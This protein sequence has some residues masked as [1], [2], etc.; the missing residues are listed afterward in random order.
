M[1]GWQSAQNWLVHCCL[2]FGLGFLSK[3]FTTA[4]LKASENMSVWI[5]VFIVFRTWL[6]T[7]LNAL[8]KN[9]VATGSVHGLEELHVMTMSQ[10]SV[11]AK[12]ANFP[13]DASFLQGFLRLSVS[14][15]AAMLALIEVTVLCYWRTMQVLHNLM[16]RTVVGQ[17]QSEV[18]GQNSGK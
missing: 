11:R 13:M 3:G 12:Q 18:D 15:L 14:T 9:A 10:T 6:K 16:Q 17:R 8:F 7:L 2:D 5:D 4:V 1:A